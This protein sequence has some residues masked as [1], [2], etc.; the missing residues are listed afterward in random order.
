MQVR[1]CG[2]ADDIKIAEID[3]VLPAF[4]QV[5]DV[6]LPA[7]LL[8]PFALEPGQRDNLYVVERVESLDGCLPGPADADHPDADGRRV[9]HAH[10][11]LLN[12]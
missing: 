12:P 2:D 10:G 11:G 3:E 9:M 1:G 7:E 4:E 5:L 6:M 8:D